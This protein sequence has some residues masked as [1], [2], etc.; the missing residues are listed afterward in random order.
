[1]EV[2]EWQ[3]ISCNELIGKVDGKYSKVRNLKIFT[4]KIAIKL[5]PILEISGKKVK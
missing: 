4:D 2:R 5:F 1:M 3:R